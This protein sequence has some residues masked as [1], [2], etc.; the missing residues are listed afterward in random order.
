MHVQ[1]FMSLS[2][3]EYPAGPDVQA[4]ETVLSLRAE[5]VSLGLAAA[6]V[7]ALQAC[8]S[9]ESSIYWSLLSARVL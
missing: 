9:A 3:A 1:G 8:G 6:D 4:V 7:G 2:V 5:E